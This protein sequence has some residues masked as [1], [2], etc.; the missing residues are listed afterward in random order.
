MD[1]ELYKALIA[2]LAFKGAY[3]SA[4]AEG[5]F[6]KGSLPHRINNPGD[7]ELGDRGNGTD[8]DKTKYLTAE[9]GWAALE[10]QWTAMLTGLSK[11]YSLHDSLQQVATRWTGADNDGAWCKIVSEY[12]GITPSTTLLEWIRAEAEAQTTEKGETA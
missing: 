3:G 9:D 7:L 2:K 6:A 8:H 10:R 5:Y 11:E 12:L 1:P 4:I